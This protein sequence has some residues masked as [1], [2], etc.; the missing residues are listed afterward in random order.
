MAETEVLCLC[1]GGCNAYCFLFVPL[2]YALLS[3][4]QPYL[5]DAL[6]RAVVSA[7]V[8]HCR[9]RHTFFDFDVVIYSSFGRKKRPF[10]RYNLCYLARKKR[11]R[12]SLEWNLWVRRLSLLESSELGTTQVEESEKVKFLFFLYI[13][14]GLSLICSCKTHTYTHLTFST[15]ENKWLIFFER[16]E[17]STKYKEE[18]MWSSP[19][20]EAFNVAPAFQLPL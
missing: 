1:I 11:R 12:H 2:H 20:R 15:T 9:A 6:N 8:T 7:C 10:L 17:N 4:P 19:F 3:F 18:N 13:L 5:A 14:I 16:F